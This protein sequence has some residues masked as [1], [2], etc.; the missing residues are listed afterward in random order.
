MHNLDVRCICYIGG[1]YSTGILQ[2][3]LIR[4]IVVSWRSYA[5]FDLFI[6]LLFPA[7]ELNTFYLDLCS[8]VRWVTNPSFGRWRVHEASGERTRVPAPAAFFYILRARRIDCLCPIRNRSVRDFQCLLN[9]YRTTRP[10]PAAA[11]PKYRV[12]PPDIKQTVAVDI[13]SLSAIN[14]PQQRQLNTLIKVRAFNIE[15]LRDT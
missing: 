11:A 14:T 8:A 5:F 2:T 10:S 15:S 6:E 12:G 1:R 7:V 4:F 3:I 13:F 9:L